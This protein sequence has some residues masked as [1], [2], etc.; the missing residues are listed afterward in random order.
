VSARPIADACPRCGADVPQR[1]KFC[2]ECATPLEEPVD[3]TIHEVSMNVSEPRW[4]GVT[5]P[6]MLLGLAGILLLVA[7]G[8]LAAG[9][10]PYAL[11]VLGLAALLL[12]AFMEAARRRPHRSRRSRPGS[13]VR[14]RA[15]SV[16]EEW[17][18]RSA[19]AAEARRVQNE[20]LAIETERSQSLHELGLAA[21]ARDGR[22]E[23]GARAH[24]NELDEREAGL[25]ALLDERLAAAG[26]RIRRAKLPVQDTIMV[27]PSEPTPPPGEAD[28][29]QPAVVPEP[30]PPPDEGTPPQ[31]AKV[32]E[33]GPRED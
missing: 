17:R 20:L 5:P 28:P 12:A 27:L 1:A 11:I 2:P 31:P 4:F 33:P 22:L 9:H 25:R 32:P 21:H 19:A 23:A 15:V 8:L 14:E 3:R 7:I 10:W 16:W 6:A 29:P 24:L 18:A 30:Y 13:E 26:E